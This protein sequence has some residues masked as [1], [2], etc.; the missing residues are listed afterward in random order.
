LINEDFEQRILP[1]HAFAVRSG[2][3]SKGAGESAES[4]TQGITSASMRK[5]L[6]QTKLLMQASIRKP[7]WLRQ[8]HP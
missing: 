3:A 2:T 7:A 6:K 1:D 5:A 4:H 8:Q